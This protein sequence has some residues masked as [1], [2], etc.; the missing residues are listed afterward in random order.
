MIK[1]TKRLLL[2]DEVDNELP[3]AIMISQKLPLLIFEFVSS[4]AESGLIEV[5]HY[6]SQVDLQRFH[7]TN[8]S[9]I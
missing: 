5:S 6:I 4:L 1:Q 2:G 7:R 8:L 9:E 3:A